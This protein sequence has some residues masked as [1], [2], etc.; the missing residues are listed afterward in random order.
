M[1]QLLTDQDIQAKL[2]Q[3]SG[4]DLDGKTIKSTRKFKD[5]VEAMSFVNK[6]I[7]PAESAGHHPDLYI[8]YN[9]VVVTLTSH[10]AGG[11]TENDF[12]MAQTISA[13][14]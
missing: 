14:A 2:S 3:I 13:I 12:S 5:F 6:L 11:L 4:W 7:D 9:T 10:D 8:S 1:A